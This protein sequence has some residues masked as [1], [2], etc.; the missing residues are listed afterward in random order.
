M[1]GARPKTK[2]LMKVFYDV[3]PTD[4][5]RS[6]TYTC[7][8][9]ND[10]KTDDS[11]SRPAQHVLGHDQHGT[12]CPKKVCPRNARMPESTKYQLCQALGWRAEICGVSD[13]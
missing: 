10:V 4:N 12:V 11:V 8:F 6:L 2:D 1:A 5:G 7:K 13:L 3:V 9:C